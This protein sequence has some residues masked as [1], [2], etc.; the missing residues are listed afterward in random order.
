MPTFRADRR[1]RPGDARLHLRQRPLA[2]QHDGAERDRQPH[3]TRVHRHRRGGRRRRPHGEEGRP[4]RRAVRLV[5]RHLRV[6]PAGTADVLPPRRLVGRRRPRR[7]PGRSGARPAGRRDARRAPRRARPRADA[8]A[9]HAL[10]RDGHRPPCSP[11]RQG[12]ARA[13]S[14]PW[15]A[16][17]RSA[18]AASSPRAGSA[19]SRSSC[20]AVTPTASRWHGVRRDR[21]RQRA[22][23]GSDRARA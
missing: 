23:R 19:P 20:S 11:R 17:A 6:L 22:R 9:A 16:T 21:H 10:R 18:S 12:R 4:G 3:G 2:V 5:R 14:S 15:S 13:R 1:A 7:R 8:V